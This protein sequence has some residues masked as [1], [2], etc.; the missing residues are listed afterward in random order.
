MIKGLFKRNSAGQ[1]VSFKL[2]GHAE[3]DTYGKDI[4]CAAVSALAISTVNGI[5]ALAGFEPII[6]TKDEQDGYLYVEMITK[7][8]QEQANIAQIL[9]ENLLLGL[10]SIEQ[11]YTE[12]IQIQTFNNK[13]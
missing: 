1:I 8:T 4:V 9:L 5:D 12:F 10:Q 7:M 13:E 3:M 6:E 2:T 11:E